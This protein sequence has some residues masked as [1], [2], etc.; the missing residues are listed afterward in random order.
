MRR[1]CETQMF[2]SAKPFWSR[3]ITEKR[4]IA[5]GPTTT[6]VAV[7]GSRSG[8]SGMYLVTRPMLPS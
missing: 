6:A 4:I 2:S 5:G 8:R 1:S 7:A 3:P